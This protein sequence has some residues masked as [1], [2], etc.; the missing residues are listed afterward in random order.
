[1]KE[2]LRHKEAFEYYYSLGGTATDKNCGK[3][4]AKI[5][6]S[7]NTIWNWYKAFNWKERVEQRTSDITAVITF[8]VLLIFFKF[9]FF[10][11]SVYSVFL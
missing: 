9:L 1:M 3:V 2:T 5:G 7:C 8:L 6:V 10:I 4:G 11:Y